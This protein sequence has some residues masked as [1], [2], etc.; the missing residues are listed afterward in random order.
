MPICPLCRKNN[1]AGARFCIRCGKEQ[2]DVAEGD[3]PATVVTR[4]RTCPDCAMCNP[5]DHA[6]CMGCG[7]SLRNVALDDVGSE[8]IAGLTGDSTKRGYQESSDAGTDLLTSQTTEDARIVHILPDGTTV[9]YSINGSCLVIGRLPEEADLSLPAD[10]YVSQKH[11]AVVERSSTYVLEDLG[12]SNGTYVRIR[13]E[14]QLRPSDT[15]RIGSQV[16][17]FVV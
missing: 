14:V 17:R 10:P 6:F 11:A 1:V 2:A 3:L 9:P 16:F 5:E 4:G 12:S 13:G 15:V 8:G 7:T